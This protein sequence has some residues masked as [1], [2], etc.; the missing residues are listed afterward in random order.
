MFL[1]LFSDL[2]VTLCPFPF[3]WTW[4]EEGRGEGVEVGSCWRKRES[5]RD[6][7]GRWVD[8]G[9][10][11]WESSPTQPPWAPAG[12]WLSLRALVRGAL[13]CE[14]PSCARGAG[15]GV[16]WAEW[17]AGARAEL[18]SGCVWPALLRPAYLR[19]WNFACFENLEDLAMVLPRCLGSSWPECGCWASRAACP[20]CSPS[21]PVLGRAWRQ[22]ST[23]GHWC[24]PVFSRSGVAVLSSHVLVAA[25]KTKAMLRGP[26]GCSQW[27]FSHLPAG[28]LW[29]EKPVVYNY[30]Y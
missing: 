30:I 15:A 1:H 23:A 4:D 3:F 18:D 5:S 29:G 19:I 24:P 26:R 13:T 2:P 10:E 8:T 16:G 12:G 27:L 17:T 11:S 14:R 6:R 9:I 22:M 25:E 28:A 20:P 21:T 7:C